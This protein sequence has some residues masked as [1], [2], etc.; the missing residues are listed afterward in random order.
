MAENNNG[1]IKTNLDA[2]EEKLGKIKN[3][4]L[5]GKRKIAYAI[6]A[7]G[8]DGVEP[9]GDTSETYMTFQ[10][11]ADLILRLRNRNAMILEFTIP[12]LTGQKNTNYKRTVVLPMNMADVTGTPSLNAIADEIIGGNTK[13][14]S[15]VQSDTVGEETTIAK[16]SIENHIVTDS[17]GNKCVDGTYTI[18]IDEINRYLTPEQRDEFIDSAAKLNAS[19]DAFGLSEEDEQAEGQAITVGDNPV[20]EYTVDWGDGHTAKY[21]ANGTYDSNKAAIWHTYN[22]GGTYKVSIMGVFRKMRTTGS[23]GDRYVVNKQFK[24]DKDNLFIYN[25]DNYGMREY[26]T[27]VIAW[28]NTSLTDCQSAF[29]GCEKLSSIPMYDTTNSFEDVTD[30]S[31]MFH[32]CTQLASLPYDVKNNKG[33][34]S[35]CKKATTFAYTFSDCTGLKCAIPQGLI[36]GC[37]EV[38]DVSGMFS[39]CTNLEQL[40]PSTIF[41]GLTKLTNAASVFENCSNVVIHPANLFKDCPNVTDISRLF[42]NCTN[43]SGVLEQNYIGNL[44][45]LKSA[46]Q[47][48]WHCSKLRDLRSGAFKN[49]KGEGIN[50]REAFCGCGITAIPADCISD[51]TGKNLMMERMFADCVNLTSLSQDELA[52]LKVAN[53]RGMFDGCSNLTCTI[54][55]NPDW[56]DNSA[57]GYKRWYSAFAGCAGANYVYHNPSTGQIESI[58]MHFE[59]SGETGLKGG[60]KDKNSRVGMIVV[61]DSTGNQDNP[62]KYVEYFDLEE[63]DANKAI[64]IVYADVL[65]DGSKTTETL[66]NGEGNVV[67]NK[68]GASNVI[69]KLYICALNDGD[70][71][72]TNGQNLCEDIPTIP[73]T[74]DV[75]V[76]YN[77][78]EWAN[79]GSATLKPTR[80]FG[81][82]YYNALSQFISGGGILL[83]GTSA[84][85]PAHKYVYE[86][87]FGNKKGFLPD[88]A[89]LWDQYVQRGLMKKSF[90][91]LV[92]ASSSKTDSNC[93][94]IKPENHYYYWSSAESTATHAW[95]LSTYDASVGYWDKWN[96]PS[97]VRPSFAITVS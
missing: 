88:A 35:N 29:H 46:R 40:V 96:Y 80:Y 27:S 76:A 38:T 9:S 55:K 6:K 84:N 78:Y 43:L 2:I 77:L 5:G 86:Y 13:A 16:D 79:T 50:F 10:Q 26:L 73:N 31:H 51:L 30:L 97:F 39:G 57:D 34:F 23:K 20:Y 18:S 87:K 24:R 71:Q 33:L 59:L 64:G 91:A 95:C 62:Y 93:Y 37:S 94:P 53:A 48:F 17:F 19:D 81:E 44:S 4:I 82:E 49:I 54:T 63:T 41:N 60:R 12:K 1:V 11:Y 56:E 42:Y 65:V 74:S 67:Q 70:K 52:N 61:P 69:H 72:W 89:D 25:N 36:N 58:L 32:G 90:D 28:G 66:K 8:I 15:T 3:L 21:N 47:A 68:N 83:D 45:K 75:N 85:Y 22:T 14:S 7:N 92:A